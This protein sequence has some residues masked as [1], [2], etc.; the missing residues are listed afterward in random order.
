MDI[1]ACTTELLSHILPQL[2]YVDVQ[3]YTLM[4]PQ[5]SSLAYLTSYCVYTAWDS[6]AD[7]SFT[8]KL[9]TNIIK[10]IVTG[11]RRG[12]TNENAQI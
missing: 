9:L 10:Y 6:V 1:A 11:E 2:L 3:S 12:T 8:L 4:E 7:V 5:L